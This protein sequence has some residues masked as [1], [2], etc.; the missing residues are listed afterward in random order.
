MQ[1]TIYGQDKGEKKTFQFLA[2]WRAVSKRCKN[3]GGK[4][5]RRVLDNEALAKLMPGIT[6]GAFCQWLSPLAIG[7][8]GGKA[9]PLLL[10][11]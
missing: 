10:V 5:Q 4:W 11:L 6:S 2:R 1:L 8:R 7:D 3:I 9:A